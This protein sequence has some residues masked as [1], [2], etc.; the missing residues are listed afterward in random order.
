MT[1]R[2]RK[3]AA[4]TTTSKRRRSFD[5]KYKLEAVDF[6][7]LLLNEKAILLR[8]GQLSMLGLHI[9]AGVKTAV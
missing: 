5:L 6:V 8:L 2:L 7:E 9:R 3:L 4:T 1:Y